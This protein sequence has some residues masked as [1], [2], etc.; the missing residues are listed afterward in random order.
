MDLQ[1]PDRF[2]RLMEDVLEMSW[3]L[4]SEHGE[5]C[6]FLKVEVFTGPFRR[7]VKTKWSGIYERAAVY[8]SEER[9]REAALTAEDSGR[10]VH[11]VQLNRHGV[12]RRYGEVRELF[13]EAFMTESVKTAKGEYRNPRFVNDGEVV[14]I[15]WRIDGKLFALR[16][17]VACAAGN[18][19]RVVNEKREVDKWL[20]LNH[21]YVPPDDPRV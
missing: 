19:A 20:P 2:K 18:E 14:F 17:E 6:T 9:A 7:V 3:A 13:E 4:E 1:Q 16:C 8:T 15:P 5:F 11:I 21:L 12:I 10:K